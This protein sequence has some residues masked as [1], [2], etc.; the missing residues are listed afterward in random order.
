MELIQHWIANYGYWGIATLLALGIVGLPIPDETLLT[1]AGYLLFR[2]EL[3]PAPTVLSAL[4]GSMS[5]ITISYLLGRTTGYPL[6]HKYGRYVRITE[7]EIHR[8]HD[9]YQRKGGLSLTFGYYIAG[10]RHLTAYAAGASKLEY[11][12]FAAY[13]YGGAALWCGTFLTLGYLLGERW[14]EILEAVHRFGLL[15]AG[16]IGAAALA[17]GVWWFRFRRAQAA[18]PGE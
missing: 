9:F 11:P 6:L 17:Y 18:N 3:K 14:N 16:V 13:A 12:V 2:G 4:A 8:V 7:H 10:V 1:F 15:A 5:G